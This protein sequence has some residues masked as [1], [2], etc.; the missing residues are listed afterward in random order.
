MTGL[1]AIYAFDDL[2]DITNYLRYGSM[3]L[4][5]RGFEKGITCYPKDNTI[6]CMEFTSLDVF[7][8]KLNTYVGIVALYNENNIYIGKASSSGT[9]VV[10]LADR[11][12]SELDVVANSIAKLLTRYLSGDIVNTLS[13]IFN[14]PDIP[15]FI[16]LTNRGEVI[17]WRSGIGLTP[18][19]L[20]GY[21]FD[22]AIVASESVA[23]DILGAEHRKDF[24]LGEGAYIS[25]YMFKVFKSKASENSAIC[26]FEL[27][28]LARPDSIVGGVSVYHFRKRLGEELASRFDKSIDIVVGVPETS[29]PYALGFSQRLGKPLELALVSTGSRQRSMLKVDPMDK[30][31]AIHLKMNPIKSALEGKRIALVD[32]SMVTGATIKTVSQLL[33]FGVGVEEIHLV[34]AS[35]PLIS[36]CPYRV[37]NLDVEK[38]IAANLNST[39]MVKYLDVDSI[40]WID[41]ESMDKVAREF[42]IRLCGKCFGRNFFGR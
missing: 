6:R 27:L 13:S 25:R 9:E 15:T 18:L 26:A 4:Q 10:V 38:L 39:L 41:H 8:H 28:Y 14:N 24:D 37:F 32:D 21:G 30:I 33:R 12:Y 40:A 34:I 7:D 35:P 11:I 29:Y 5:H 1:L 20:G 31:I 36:N 3:A 16:A 22:M 42:G 23:I 17:V 19:V 2:W